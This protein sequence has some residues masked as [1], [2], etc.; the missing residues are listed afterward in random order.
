MIYPGEYSVTWKKCVLYSWNVLL[1]SI[2]SLSC[3]MW[4][5]KAIIFLLVFC[6]DDLSVDVS[7]V[8]NPLLLL[9]YFG[10]LSLCSLILITESLKAFKTEIQCTYGYVPYSE[11]G[12]KYL[13]RSSWSRYILRVCSH[14][15]YSHMDFTSSALL[16]G[17][18]SICEH[19]FSY[20]LEFIP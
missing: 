6:M 15:H 14:T 18:V 20:F 9:Y 11:Q 12:P 17:P 8:L 10:F 4:H 3:L 19:L 16:F 13:V 5:F 2:W 7:G 1:M